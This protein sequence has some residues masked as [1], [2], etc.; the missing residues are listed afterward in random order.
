MRSK[1]GRERTETERDIP[2][3]SAHRGCAFNEQKY[4]YLK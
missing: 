2:A 4:K 3:F 1:I